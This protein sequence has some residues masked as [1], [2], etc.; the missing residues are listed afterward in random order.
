MS[1]MGPGGLSHIQ[2]LRRT[3]GNIH[4][5]GTEMGTVSVGYMDGAIE[6][7]IRAANEVLE[8]FKNEAENVEAKS[9]TRKDELPWYNKMIRRT[10]KLF[11]WL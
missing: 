1:I 5:G 11:E 8:K 7:G 9:E 2:N 4:F 10:R 3:E 6:S